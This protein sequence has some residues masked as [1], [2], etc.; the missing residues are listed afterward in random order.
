MRHWT[1]SNLRISNSILF[2]RRCMKCFQ[3]LFERTIDERLFFTGRI[4]INIPFKRLLFIVLFA[5]GHVACQHKNLISERCGV[6]SCRYL[7][8]CVADSNTCVFPPRKMHLNVLFSLVYGE[9]AIS[10]CKNWLSPCDER[11]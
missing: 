5:F 10:Y 7:E 8:M 6:A 3:Q 2:V 9:R 1:I 11:S 4:E